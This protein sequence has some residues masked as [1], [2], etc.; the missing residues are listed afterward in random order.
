VLIGGSLFPLFAAFYYW[1]PKWTGRMLDERLGA[2]NFWLFF[3]GFNLAFFP[4]HILGLHGMTRRIYTYGS[5][6]GWAG[7]NLLATVGA[8]ILGLAVLTFLANV[9]R[10]LK[11]G[12]LAGDN[13]WG[14]STLDW[15][16]TSPPPSYNFLYLPTV[17]GREPL[18]EQVPISPVVTGL[19]TSR[20][21][22]LTTTILEAIEDHRYELAGDS[23]WP[24]LLAIVVGGSIS[25]GVFTAWAIPAGAFLSL[26]VLT[27]WFWHGD[28][29]KR[30]TSTKQKKAAPLRL[31][32]AFE[33]EVP[34]P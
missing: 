14:A 11:R 8:G 33:P 26:L 34:A 27:A 15:A 23:I 17:R 5:E 4:M 9:M 6:T 22:V 21:E 30:L 13:P 20:R 3:I 28:A 18:W 32:A 10:S 24:L 25:W 2:L 12:A 16:T 1:F 19:S 31:P 29:P 7:M